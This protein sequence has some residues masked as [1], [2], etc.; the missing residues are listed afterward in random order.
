MFAFKK[1]D[2]EHTFH[3]HNF[4]FKGKLMSEDAMIND[5]EGEFLIDGRVKLRLDEI[6][7]LDSAEFPDY[8]RLPVYTEKVY[9]HVYYFFDIQRSGNFLHIE[10]F[11]SLDTIKRDNEI[12]NAWPLSREMN[13]IAEKKKID[14]F[15]YDE[16]SVTYK[17]TLPAKGK[18]GDAIKKCIE[19][20]KN[21]YEEAEKNLIKI[22]LK[23]YS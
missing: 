9:G 4:Y 13:E 14:L 5:K 18:L 12:F 8:F 6:S 19:Q 16:S 7:E 11:G 17:F 20:G 10:I 1:K 21:I 22:A 3:T 2:G 15:E 23:H